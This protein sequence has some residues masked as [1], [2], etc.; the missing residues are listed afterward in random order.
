MK[1]IEYAPYEKL[2]ERDRTLIDEGI[3][4]RKEAVWA[5]KLD[6]GLVC[7]LAERTGCPFG[8]EPSYWESMHVA[9]AT[10]YAWAYAVQLLD[11]FT[12]EWDEY[13]AAEGRQDVLWEKLGD[14]RRHELL[15]LAASRHFRADLDLAADEFRNRMLGDDA[16]KVMWELDHL[17]MLSSPNLN[18]EVAV[19][20]DDFGN[21]ATVRKR[22]TYGYKDAPCRKESL[23]LALTADYDDVTYHVSVYESMEEVNAA[24]AKFSC[25]TWH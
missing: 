21:T 6:M 3:D 15:V 4:A 24:L 12:S 14:D 16:G 17:E 9:G 11:R 23:V 20:H 13:V 25:G 5:F 2:S 19:Y 10:A 8:G 7:E 1:T 22:M 18:G